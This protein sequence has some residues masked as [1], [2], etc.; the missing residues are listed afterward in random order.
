MR[1]VGCRAR[2]RQPAPARHRAGDPG[3]QLHASPPRRHRCVFVRSARSGKSA[4]HFRLETVPGTSGA[5]P[6]VLAGHVKWRCPSVRCSAGRGDGAPRRRRQHAAD[7]AVPGKPGRG[8][9][10][11]GRMPGTGG[12]SR[13]REWSDPHGAA[14]ARDGLRSGGAERVAGSA[15]GRPVRDGL[16]TSPASRRAH[17]SPRPFR[18][19]STAR[20]R[21]EILFFSSLVICA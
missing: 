1:A 12:I 17:W 4:G 3:G 20:L 18:I 9:P 2:E 8:R 6:T 13:H 5:V 16:R 10:Q 14:C 15:P 11:P 19:A 21:W 7:I